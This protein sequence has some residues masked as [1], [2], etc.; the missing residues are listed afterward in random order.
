M[1]RRPPRSTPLYSSAASDVYKRQ[2]VTDRAALVGLVSE[3]RVPGAEVHRGDA[4]LGEAGDV[5]PAVLGCGYPTRELEDGRGE[6]G[7][8]GVVE[9]GPGTGRA[10]DD[11]DLVA[12]ELARAG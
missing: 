7:R 2:E 3:Q 10:V 9:T 1:I 8:G 12:V 6:R 5:R 4:E 11:D